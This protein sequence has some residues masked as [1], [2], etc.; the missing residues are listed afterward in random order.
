VY[1]S[2]PQHATCCFTFLLGQATTPS[3]DESNTL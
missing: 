1:P 2:M 3:A